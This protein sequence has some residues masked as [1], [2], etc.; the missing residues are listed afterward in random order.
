MVVSVGQLGNHDSK[1]VKGYAFFATQLSRTAHLAKTCRK[2]SS[3]RLNADPVI[4]SVKGRV[5]N[6]ILNELRK[7]RAALP[8][9]SPPPIPGP[10]I[11]GRG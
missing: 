8:L 6:R 11:R 7:S 10:V 3:P 2:T 5:N 9:A 1:F 4:A